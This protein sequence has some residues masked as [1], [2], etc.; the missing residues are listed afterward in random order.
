MRRYDVMLENG[1]ALTFVGKRI[2]A[3]EARVF[4]ALRSQVPIDMPR[5]Y[6]AQDG[7]CVMEALPPAKSPIE[8]TAEDAR[9]ALLNLARLHAAFWERP[10]AWP[11]RMD[12]ADLNQRLDSAA[13]GLAL[14]ERMGGWPGLIEPNLM[15]AMHRALDE[16]ERFIAALDAQPLTLLHGDAWMSNWHITGARCTLLDWEWTVVGPAVWDVNYFLEIA[17]VCKAVN[18]RW[19]VCLPPIERE[20]ATAFYLDQLESVLG[21]RVERA[22]FMSALPAAFVINTLTFWMGYAERYRAQAS[23]LSAI[24]HLI[25]YLPGPLRRAFERIAL[26]EQGDYLRRTFARF[27]SLIEA[28]DKHGAVAFS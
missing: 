7:W 22:A 5:I 14:I 20:E 13:R 18:G 27:E 11:D 26:S 28:P 1:D 24:G 9:T 23:A 6:F 19:Q 3:L 12:A 4:T 15:R 16:R 8:W 21:R 2:S 17:A 25:K 10:P